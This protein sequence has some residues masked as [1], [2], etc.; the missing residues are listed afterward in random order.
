[1]RRN[2][3]TWQYLIAASSLVM[4]AHASA[5]EAPGTIPTAEI[6]HEVSLTAVQDADVQAGA[7]NQNY[8]SHTL[9]HIGNPDKTVYVG[10]DVSDI[11]AGATITRARLVMNVAGSGTGDNEVKLG[12]VRGGWREST[13]TYDNQPNVAWTRR[14]N[15][16]SV[17]GPVTWNVK[18]AVEGWV[19]GEHRNRGFAIRSTDQGP[20]WAF[21]SREGAPPESRPTLHV[22]YTTTGAVIDPPRSEVISRT[23]GRN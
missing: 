22:A 12:A 1:M 20:I 5:S 2:R 8:G 7:P 21:V 19:S 10:F 16:I 13:I 23:G 11:P 17:A 14:T 15:V 6:P 18:A 4:G 9:M 3:P